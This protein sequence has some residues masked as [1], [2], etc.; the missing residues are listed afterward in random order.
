MPAKNIQS[1]ERAEKTP[2]L[3]RLVAKDPFVGFGEYQKTQTPCSEL[4]TKHGVQLK[5]M[6]GA[7]ALKK[8]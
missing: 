8:T 6:R 3:K 2:E 5:N 1:D 4:V 7:T